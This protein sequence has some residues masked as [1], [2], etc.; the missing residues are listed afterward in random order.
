MTLSELSFDFASLRAA[1]LEGVVSPTEVVQEVNRRITAHGDDAVWIHRLPEAQL[2]PYLDALTKRSAVDLP[3]FGL[4]FAIKDNID[5]ANVP[6]TAGCP[7]FAYT[8]TE[9]APVVAALVNAGAIP[10]GKTNLDQFAT[11]LV[12]VRSPYGTPGNSFDPKYIPGG[13]SSGSAVAVA[14]GMVS[15][16]LGTDTAGSGRVPASFNNLVGL[17]PTKG[18]FSTR[19]VVPAC[20]SLDCVSIFSLTV[21][22]AVDVSHV[23]GEFDSEDPFARTAVLTSPNEGAFRFG[24]PLASQLEWFG[25]TA[26]PS[27][28]QTAIGRLEAQGGVKT[29]IDFS[30]FAAAARLLYEGPW[31]AERWSAIREFYADHADTLHPTTRK[32]IEG[33]AT[34]LAVDAFEAQYRL[35]ELKRQADQ[36]WQAIDTLVLPTTPSI[37]TQAE[38]AADP[39]ELNSRLGTYTNFANLL[40]T[41]ALAVPVGLRSD[42]L[43]FGVTLFGPAWSDLRLATIGHTLQHRSGLTVGATGHALSTRPIDIPAASSDLLPLA[44]VGAHLSGQPLNTQLTDCGAQLLRTTKT[45]SNYKFYALAGGPPFKPGLQR[46]ERGGGAIEVEIWGLPKT[47]WAEFVA[48]IPPPHGVGTLELAD[49]TTVPGYQCEPIALIDAVD[50][51]AFGSWR[52]Y[53]QSLQPSA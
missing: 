11:G 5:L 51:T 37:Y 32:I 19:G 22:D 40:D 1:Y 48:S 9:S 31:V 10:I 39:I 6:T 52:A 47:E 14:T 24:V 28:F 16:G 25:D 4:P 53:V 30:P 12:G 46:V 3:L 20:R 34:P 15:F 18:W 27:L 2:A 23:M 13:S 50:I 42:G 43:P 38:L 49:G 33:G 36:V 21:A 44:V 7:E 29:E 8:P 17:K 35:A 26:H 45:A 41:A